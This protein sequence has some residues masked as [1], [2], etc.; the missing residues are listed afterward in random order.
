MQPLRDL[1]AQSKAFRVVLIAVAVYTVLRGGVQAV[2]LSG[3][4]LPDGYDGADGVYLP[5]DM[6]VYLEA[7]QRLL[8]RQPLYLTGPLQ[9]VEFFQYTPAFALLFV[10][11]TWVS[12][13]A[14]LVIHSLI[15]IAAYAWLYVL[16]ARL[17]ERLG[18]AGAARAL[19]L[20][21]PVWLVY[22]TFWADW[23]YLNI[24]VVMAV[25]GTLL[26]EAVL[27]ENLWLAAL[28]LAVILQIKPHWA[29]AAGVPLL[30]GRWRF[31]ARLALLGLGGYALLAGATMALAGPGYVWAQYAA[32]ARFLAGLAGNFPWREAAARYPGYNHS[33]LQTLVFWLGAAPPAFW[34]A[35][36][37]KVLLT[38][39]LAVLGLRQAWA[40]PSLGPG[41]AAPGRS[42]DLAFALYLAGFIWLDWVWE[43]ALGGVLFAYLWASQPG[44]SARI[45]LAAVFLPFALLDFWQLL[46][47]IVFGEGV[48]DGAY[49]LTDPSIY[50]PLILFIIVVFYAALLRRLFQQPA[51]QLAAAHQRA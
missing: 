26:L 24:Y 16:W 38:A 46:S 37:I 22:S 27:D 14:V 8:D 2:Y 9:Q 20:A 39:P 11:F 3:A 36:V 10:P 28:W 30:L 23:A 34:L 4:L 6:R 45:A 29:F 35:T 1:W 13:G 12:N 5:E 40:N 25:L 49:I 21:L 7:S 50:L 17:F 41:R 47:V 48:V 42:L 43:L 32:Y 33:I 19:A 51:A 31:F 44:R 15:H 18:L